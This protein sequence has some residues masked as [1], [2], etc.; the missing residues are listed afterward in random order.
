MIEA[1]G[2]STATRAVDAATVRLPE[3]FSL[4][5]AAA[6]TVLTTSSA[7]TTLCRVNQPSIT[8]ASGQ[9]TARSD[10]PFRPGG[11]LEGGERCCPAPPEA[12]ERSSRPAPFIG[13]FSIPKPVGVHRMIDN[14]TQAR[15]LPPVA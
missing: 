10:A 13:Q 3:M 8:R 5:Q 1:S 4:V 15:E 7:S 2:K 12:P 11:E 14:G 6:I 9:Q